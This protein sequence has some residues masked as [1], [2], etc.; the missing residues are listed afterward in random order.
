[1]IVDENFFM[2]YARIHADKVPFSRL[3]ISSLEGFVPSGW[4]FPKLTPQD[5][6]S[7]HQREA[8]VQTLQ[9]IKDMGLYDSYVKMAEFNLADRKMAETDNTGFIFVHSIL[10]SKTE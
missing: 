3:H 4:L 8:I 2:T 10:L 6:S 7:R 5:N 1:M 9:W